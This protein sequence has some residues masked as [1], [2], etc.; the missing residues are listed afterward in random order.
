[1]PAWTE[2]DD[3]ETISTF[4]FPTIE[5]QLSDKWLGGATQSFMKGVGDVFVEAGQ[6]SMLRARHL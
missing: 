1:M 6:R 5:E 2:E 4:V 3:E